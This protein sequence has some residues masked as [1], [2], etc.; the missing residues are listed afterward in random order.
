MTRTVAHEI[1]KVPMK[2]YQTDNCRVNKN[3]RPYDDLIVAL[4]LA[5]DMSYKDTFSDLML[6]ANEMY[7]YPNLKIVSDAYLRGKGWGYNPRPRGQSYLLPRPNGR[8]RLDEWFDAPNV[9][10]LKVQHGST[11]VWVA[12]VDGIVHGA[13]PA[14][15]NYHVC[16]YWT[17]P[18][19]DSHDR[20]T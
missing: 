14:L 6:T 5:L 20:T 15:M 2:Y 9:A 7:C 10:A 3:M 18:K 8:V 16:G 1:L 12:I 17:P 11:S 13:S 4:S 19:E